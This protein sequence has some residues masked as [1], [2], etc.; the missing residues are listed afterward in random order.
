MEWEIIVKN[1]NGLIRY[2]IFIVLLTLIGMFC[3]IQPILTISLE[4]FSR[5]AIIRDASFF[6]N[7]APITSAN[8]S[9]HGE[10]EED[11][12]G[13]IVT[14]AGNVNGDEF[15]DFLISAPGNSFG[16]SNAGM[17]YLI[18]GN[19][20]GWVQDV[21]LSHADASFY[22]EVENDWSGQ[23][24]AGAGDINGDGFDDM[25]IGAPWHDSMRGR[26]YLIF[27]NASGWTINTN[28]S[29][30]D[31]Y[32]NGE[33]QG[34]FSGH[35]VTGLGDVNGDEFD[36]FLI[37][38]TNYDQGGYAGS[39]AG[40]IY[41]FFGRSEWSSSISLSTANA[42]FHGE[43]AWDRLG[44][45]VT[46]AG[47]VNGDGLN[48]TLVSAR[49]SNPSERGKAYLIYGKKT[50]WSPSANI[51]TSEAS[52]V[53]IQNDSG[54]SIAG[55]G[56]VNADGFD[57]LLFGEAANSEIESNLGKIFLLLGKP[58]T[59]TK[60]IQLNSE[61]D[62]S[63]YGEHAE[64][65][66]GH[67]VAGIGDFNGDNFDDI[68]IGAKGSDFG[69]PDAGKAYLILGKNSGW[70]FRANISS[71]V[72]A[73]FYGE[74]EG[75]GKEIHISRAGDLNG[76]NFDDILIGSFFNDDGGLEAGKTYVIFG[77]ETPLDQDSLPNQNQ[78]TLKDDFL[79]LYIILSILIVLISIVLVLVVYKKKKS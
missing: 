78:T 47:D 14:C 19:K 37:S 26:T 15:D 20:T 3:T 71:E 4:S 17:T 23:C 58:E 25:L 6:Q 69:A 13:T 77:T 50:G 33:E 60:N 16:G 28:L 44:I 79:A 11:Y 61:A 41:L 67:S 55:A 51:S 18:L 39:Y 48:D 57:D 62:I 59:F 68:V 73:S 36:D 40:K 24:V 38:A 75:D 56:D 10:F 70:K 66:F 46:S 21:N 1:K 53:G 54:I 8:A 63:F 22:G 49:A 45:C 30:S 74:G 9:Y 12:S 64:D 43:L 65:G 7:N 42:S 32:F 76:D 2:H 35:S 5:G 52:F 34:D 27:G 72:N 29:T 31:V